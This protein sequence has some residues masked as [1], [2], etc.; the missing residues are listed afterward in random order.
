[1]LQSLKNNPAVFSE[2]Q[3]LRPVT[4]SFKVLASE[5][6][7]LLS[8]INLFVFPLSKTVHKTKT[9]TATHGNV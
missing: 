3:L 2:T 9:Q 8:D 7:L 1:M 4:P 6:G 5:N